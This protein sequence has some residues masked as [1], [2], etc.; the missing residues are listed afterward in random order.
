L[1]HLG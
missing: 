1:K